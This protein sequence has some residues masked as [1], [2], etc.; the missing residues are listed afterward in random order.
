M[1]PRPRIA[2]YLGDV[3]GP[4]RRA[5]LRELLRL[6]VEYRRAAGEQP[7]P[8]DYSQ[9]TDQAG[10]IHAA[11]S[12]QK[13]GGGRTGAYVPGEAAQPSGAE[14]E[15]TAATVSVPG[16]EIESVLGRGGMGV[17]YKA[18]HL[19][20]NR[21]VALK[22]VLAGG[23]AGPRERA[24][25]RIEAEAVAR[26]QYPNI[27][28][29]H[30]VGEA[31]GH[32]YCALEFVEGG[33]L[34]GKIGGKPMP[35]RAAAKLVE[36]LARAMQ[37]AH[38][39]NVVHRDLKP[40]NVL[41]AADG[42]PKIT[43]FGL[44]RLL[45]SISGET[46]PD[47]VMGTPS[48][49]APEQASGHAHE[50]GPAAD[51]HALGAILYE[52]L[53]GRPPFQGKTKVETLNQVQ[54]QEPVPPSSFQAGVP[55]DVETI[56]MK[57]LRKEPENRYASSAELADDLARYQRDE[58]ILARPVGRAERVFKLV[59]RNPV[60]AGLL[61]AFLLALLI[62]L[63]GGG[64]AIHQSIQAAEARESQARADAAKARADAAKAR[65]EQDLLAAQLAREAEKRQHAI[66][67]ALTAAMGADLE[68]ADQA[69]AEA[70]QAGA[71]PGQLHMRRGQIALHR[72][73]SRDAIRHLKEAV[74]LLPNSVAAWGMLAAA[75]ADDGHWERYDKAIREMNRLTPSTP[76]DFLF[77]GYAEA[78]LE[79][80]QGLQTIKQAFDGRPPMIIALLLR[81]EVRAMVAQDTD[82]FDEA[83]RAVQDA[84]YA[85]ELLHNNPTALW[86]S[87]QAHLAK[88][89]VHEHRDELKQR[90]AELDLA[91]EDA[92]ALKAH[93]DL[94][95]AVVYRWTY[96]REVGREERVL[97]ELLCASDHNDHV[98]VRSCCALALYRRGKPGDF[99]EA[100]RV[101]KNRPGTYNYT[102]RLL[103][104]VLAEL[105]YPKEHDW[106]DRALKAYE[107]FAETA[108]DGAA[109]MDTQTVLC[110]LGQKK[111]AVKA[112]QALLKQ[113]DRFYT[114]RREPIL[115]CVRYNAGELSAE[116]LLK[117][118]GR[119]RW[120]QCLAHYSIAMTKLADGDRKGAKEHFDK[121][122]KTRA[123]GW[124]EYD[125]SWVLL[126]RLEKDDNW[127]PWI[128]KKP[129][130]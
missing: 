75:Y 113:K 65:A 64:W 70:E 48:Y 77:K 59:K 69:I 99:E 54:T 43:D 1:K 44:A 114:L 23:H 60:V 47:A 7:A 79:P 93:I 46:G 28:Q 95:E 102:D 3:Q 76:E 119:S 2:D 39:R 94:P 57:C 37:L 104:F 9:F 34:A 35:A 20:L 21:T 67:R 130:K 92:D 128:P 41:V 19:A 111:L 87:L 110:L 14:P 8:E 12:Q 71:S 58:P 112:S 29:I 53:S 18:R 25:F 5:L 98:S 124:G 81:A 74:G 120:D 122:V 32:P 72:G 51:L 82:S 91:G 27:V 11:L 55:L 63:G 88:A 127:P 129:A 50:A 80:E 109:I 38:S 108:Q 96:F 49:M 97:G 123:S 31:D 15:G 101:L 40:A 22:M 100:L 117:H 121:A 4:E 30:E 26:L 106:P 126:S 116:E 89:G 90:Q 13:V 118:A 78:Y 66:D 33:N 45:D 62:A 103:P 36:A 115:R 42:T 105:D 17:V 68:G 107:K 85:K 10:L 61:A 52:C 86:V 6:D 16:Y 24:R 125:M 83:E 84:K 73:Q 56:C